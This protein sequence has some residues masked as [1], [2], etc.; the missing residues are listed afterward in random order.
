[1]GVLSVVDD[2]TALGGVEAFQYDLAAQLPKL[3]IDFAAVSIKPKSTTDRKLP[4]WAF[5]YPSSRWVRGPL[6]GIRG[7]RFLCR[8]GQRFFLAHQP[9]SLSFL[10]SVLPGI[11]WPMLSVVHNDST[12]EQYWQSQVRW[13]DRILG[14]VAV[15][16]VIR[17][18]LIEQWGLESGRVWTIPCGIDTAGVPSAGRVPPP[19]VSR[20]ISLLY[21]GRLSGDVK[22]VLDLVGVVQALNQSRLPSDWRVSVHVAGDGPDADRLRQALI[23]VA[24]R[25]QIKWHG[26]IPRE[27]LFGIYERAHFVLL[28]SSSEG[29]PIALR[30]AMSRGAV[31]VVTDIPAHGEIITA[32]LNGFLFPPGDVREC[33]RLCC[34]LAAGEEYQQ[35]SHN[36]ALSIRDHSVEATA[37][38]Y[39]MLIER[40]SSSI[41]DGGAKAYPPT[42]RA[43]KTQSL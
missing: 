34:S 5:D 14:Y 8:F 31:P 42:A 13:K 1:M 20:R 2:V 4:S 21:V 10:A 7:R 33:A 18:R 37:Q 11:R 29:M 6:S 12:R 39:A 17:E 3:G 41:L 15:S 38:K 32:G 36:A 28:L 43:S 25:V 19:M 26:R 16:A 27:Q 40:F 30:E 24:G 23:E 35:V 9:S 22:R